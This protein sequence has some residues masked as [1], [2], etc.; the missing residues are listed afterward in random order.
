MKFSYIKNQPHLDG[1]E[2]VHRM[3][4]MYERYIDPENGYKSEENNYLYKY[5][6]R[7]ADPVS[8]F[9][10]FV[11]DRKPDFLDLDATVRDELVKY[12]TNYFYMI[13]GTREVL[14]YMSKVF[15]FTYTSEPV[16]TGS[17]IEFVINSS[18]ISWVN[19]EGAFLDL[20]SDFLKALLYISNDN[21]LNNISTYGFTSV[22]IPIDNIIEI[23]YENGIHVYKKV[24]AQY[25]NNES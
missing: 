15:G 7:K 20:L 13:K 5:T 25:N 21:V 4:M 18:S 19:D 9:T 17:D 11:Y 22:N 3:R 1:I 2:I 23:K 24:I 8:K 6:I 16:Y 12:H 10:E 14:N